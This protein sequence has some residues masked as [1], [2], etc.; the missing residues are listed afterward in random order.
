MD[1]S[2]GPINPLQKWAGLDNDPRLDEQNLHFTTN[3]INEAT[4]NVN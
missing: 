1:L 3:L 2:I 4:L